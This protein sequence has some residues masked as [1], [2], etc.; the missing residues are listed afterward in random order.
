MAENP[1]GEVGAGCQLMSKS[2]LEQEGYIVKEDSEYSVGIHF[3]EYGTYARTQM[4]IYEIAKPEV[5]ELA[6][7]TGE[8][9]NHMIEEHGAGTY[10]HRSQGDRAVQVEAHVGT[11][12]N[13]HS[14]ALGRA[15]LSYFPRERVGEIIDRHGLKPC[16]PDTTTDAHELFDELT[17]IRD[18]GFAFGDEE[19]IQGLR[20][21]AAPILSNNNRVLGAVSVSGTSNRI[22]GIDFVKNY[23]PASSRLSTSLNSMSLTPNP[24]GQKLTL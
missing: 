9:T 21:V 14:T 19:R 13:L 23:Q 2:T 16:T 10:L 8:L 4:Q 17:Q 24:S 12:V 18:E 3:L 22:R 6:D 20:C 11:R 5:D 7:T 15:M 1:Q